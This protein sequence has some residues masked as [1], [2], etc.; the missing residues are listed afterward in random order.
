MREEL[1]V[2]GIVLGGQEYKEKDMLITIFTVEI[3]KISASM[4]GVKLSKAK[5]KIFAQSFCMAEFVLSK[6]GQFYTIISAQLIDDFLDI[7]KDMDAYCIGNMILEIDNLMMKPGIVSQQLFL[8]TIKS[9][10]AI[11]HEKIKPKM[12]AS[13][14]L[15]EV[16]NTSGNGWQFTTCSSCGS[17]YISDVFLDLLN[18]N[19]CCRNC[20]SYE[21]VA[22]S[23]SE[24]NGLKLINNC[25]VDSLKTLK[26]KD[27]L[28][29][30]CFN[31]LVNNFQVQNEYKIKS[32]IL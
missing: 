12:V 21:S 2:A 14:F 6:T 15:L 19:L 10:R 7:T 32:L 16:M 5:L 24:F 13:K 4:R 1:K 29:S 17:K 30:S 3:G 20:A 28:V 8:T 27:G 25:S 18:G 26:L 9:L 11:V 23:R 31:L 22:L